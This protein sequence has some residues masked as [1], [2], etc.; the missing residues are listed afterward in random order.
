MEF[1]LDEEVLVQWTEGE[2]RNATIV[3][4]FGNKYVVELIEFNSIRLIVEESQL[5]KLH[6]NK[7]FGSV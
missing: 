7:F 1:S 3:S 6:E 2:L 4:L 5:Q